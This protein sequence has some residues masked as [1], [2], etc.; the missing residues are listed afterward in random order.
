MTDLFNDQYDSSDDTSIDDDLEV[1]IDHCNEES[2]SSDEN[3]TD[4]AGVDE[5]EVISD[6]AAENP[7]IVVT[8]VVAKSGLYQGVNEL[9]VRM[10]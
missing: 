9:N 10:Q 7:R 8:P 4:E 5:P 6:E 2:E 1:G 3:E